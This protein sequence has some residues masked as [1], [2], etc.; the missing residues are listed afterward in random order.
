MNAAQLPA[1]RSIE[2]FAQTLRISL[3]GSEFDWLDAGCRPVA[4]FL[5]P[6]IG[7]YAEDMRRRYAVDALVHRR[8]VVGM[9]KHHK[10]GEF[11]LAEAAGHLRQREQA[12][13][14]C[15]EREESFILVPDGTVRNLVCGAIV[16]PMEG[17]YGNQERDPGRF[18]GGA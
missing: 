5:H 3:V 16:T 4:A 11:L 13:G 10:V 15:G 12:F 9:V 7:S 18:A 17:A 6:A 1:H 14:R 8:C 2:A